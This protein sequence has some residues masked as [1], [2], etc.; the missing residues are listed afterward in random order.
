MLV[1]D[2]HSGLLRKFVNY[3]QKSFIT[4]APAPQEEGIHPTALPHGAKIMKLFFFF[5]PSLG[6]QASFHSQV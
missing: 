3:G 6:K 4:L 1:G 5:T 2:K